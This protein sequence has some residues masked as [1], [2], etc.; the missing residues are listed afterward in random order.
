MRPAVRSTP[1]QASTAPPAAVSLRISVTDRCQFRCGYCMPP[2]GVAC[3]P[4]ETIL[5]YEEITQLVRLLQK[6]VGVGKLRLTGGEPLVR[7]GLDRLVAMLA[8]LDIPDLALTTN[9]VLLAPL[10]ARLKAAGLGRVN[11]SLD[12]LA[13]DLFAR[14]TGRHAVEAVL[15]G[16]AAARECGLAPIKLNTVVIKGVNDRELEP[17]VQ[18]AIDHQLEV[19]FIELMPIGLGAATYPDGFLSTADVR[20][21][22]EASF[23]FAPAPSE[24]GASARRHRVTDRDG[25]RGTVGF[26]SSC[27]QPF[28][29]GC[30]RLR[31]TAGG[32]IIG[33]L[34]RDTG[35]PVRESLRRGDTDALRAAVQTALDGKRTDAR[36]AQDRTMSAIGG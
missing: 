14:I 3:G 27:S 35:I 6:T 31:C 5:T 15:D 4:R 12:A 10:A 36:F 2:E 33:C 17:I 1:A 26:I 23:T 34:A 8:A 11:I 9:A 29:N 24:P 20:R 16:I 30:R 28:C 7:P 32:E 18:Y 25:R 19:R 21:A 13:P 22:L